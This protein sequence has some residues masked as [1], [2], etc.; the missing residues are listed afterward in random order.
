M[1]SKLTPFALLGYSA[2]AENVTVNVREDRSR[3]LLKALKNPMLSPRVRAQAGCV[4]G[5][6]TSLDRLRAGPAN[7]PEV[8]AEYE[9]SGTKYNDPWTGINVLFDDYASTTK[10]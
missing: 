4:D 2:Y 8:I 6:L 9:K 3:E 10:K 7:F 1:L 5:G